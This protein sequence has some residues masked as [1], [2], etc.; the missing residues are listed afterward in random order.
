MGNYKVLAKWWVSMCNDY[1]K[2][3]CERHEYTYEPD[4]W[5]GD[6]AGTIVCIND[7]FISMNDIRYDVDNQVP[8]EKFEKWYWKGLD[9]FELTGI[10]YMN[11]PSYC[12][13]APDE[14]DD[15]RLEKI[16]DAKQ[17]IEEE[18]EKLEEMINSFKRDDSLF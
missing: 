12:K 16:R 18:R 8:L 17:H 11:Y 1:L 7:M 2:E 9:V 10:H 13:G 5:V 3:F 14:W 15:E 6:E 4:A